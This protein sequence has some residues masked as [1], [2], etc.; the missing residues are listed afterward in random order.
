MHFDVSDVIE[1]SCDL[2]EASGSKVQHM[3][4]FTTWMIRLTDVPSME[5]IDVS[6]VDKI[7]LT[8]LG[9]FLQGRRHT[10]AVQHHYVL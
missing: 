4:P 8:F 10:E 5:H 3:T 1:L 6:N 9:S 2:Y 7:T